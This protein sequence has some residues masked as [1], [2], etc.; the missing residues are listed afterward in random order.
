M[1]SLARYL[2]RSAGLMPRRSLIALNCRSFSSTTPILAPP[3]DPAIPRPPREPRP[4]ELPAAPEYSPDQLTQEERSL[5]DMLSA[6]DRAKFDVDNAKMVAEY[7]DPAKRAKMFAEIDKEVNHLEREFP[8]RF[9]ETLRGKPRGFW[10]EDEDDE[11]GIVDDTGEV[12]RDDE[13]TTPAHAEL[14]LHREM[15]EYARI[16]A[17]DMPFLSKLAQPFTLPPQTHILRFRYT[18]Y[19]GESHPAENKV[20]VELSS[21][22]LVPTYLSEEQRQ[23][24]LKIVGPR[25]NPDTDIVRMSCEKFATR[26]QNK[27]YLGDLVG[28]LLKEAKEGD[29]F[30]DIPLDL[31]HHKPKPKV[32]FPESWIMTET[33]K[34]QL[35]ATRA[36]RIRLAHERQ[37]T[38]DGKSV[39]TE[40]TKVLPALNP[41]LRLKAAEE[42]E[43]VAVRLSTSKLGSKRKIY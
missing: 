15:R 37:V 43:K 19:L 13:I 16:T 7:N 20:V 9:E 41:A 32:T 26:A 12:V 40:A 38:V 39:I 3:D 5:Y 24:F 6:E 25:F 29:S 21:R 42:R 1:A 27:R 8:Q 36:E 33:R 35:A 17:W 11:F 34:K 14:E 31:R 30:A 2:G 18:T 28:T 10:T 4:E 22:D 23:T